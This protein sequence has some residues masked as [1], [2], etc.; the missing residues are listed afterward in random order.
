MS[1]EASILS[2]RMAG[3]KCVTYVLR[4]ANQPCRYDV[5]DNISDAGDCGSKHEDDGF[6]LI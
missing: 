5:L 6:E 1:T 3:F 2:N 4:C